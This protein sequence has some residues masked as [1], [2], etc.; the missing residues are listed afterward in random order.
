MIFSLSVLIRNLRPYVSSLGL[1]L[2]LGYRVLRS[3]TASTWKEDPTLLQLLV[4]LLEDVQTKV[5]RTIVEY[6]I[7][8]TLTTTI[9][10]PTVSFVFQMLQDVLGILLLVSACRLTYTIYHFSWAE[11]KLHLEDSIFEWAKD[12]VSTVSN[13]LEEETQKMTPGMEVSL[14]KAPF[15]KSRLLS[16]PSQ[17]RVASGVLEELSGH[18]SKENSYWQAGKM[19]GTVYTSDEAH[20]DFMN[21]IY[22]LY[23]VANALHPG[24][25][26]SQSMR[27][28]IGGH[29]M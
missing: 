20:I 4:T 26:P 28:R 9:L 7:S 6:N 1:V 14:G 23:S 12:N 24:V 8:S 17:G 16:L 15:I 2:W 10:L 22:G 5:W 19:S 11:T 25:A 18:A 29:D 27:S 3:M 21:Q 13:Y